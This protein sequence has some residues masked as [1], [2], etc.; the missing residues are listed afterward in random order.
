M[1]YDEFID[2]VAEHGDLSREE[3]EEVTHATL[4]TLAE[5]ITGGEADDVASQLPKR[6]QDPL[7]NTNE[8]AETFGLEEFKRR[9][10]ERGAEVDDTADAIRA[11]MTTLREALTG[12]EFDDLMDQL[13][14]EF[15]GIVEPAGTA[16]PSAR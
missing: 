10:S 1:T 11:V 7:R 4:Q 14:D 9:V 3:A 16:R 5:R 13:P 8:Q 15:W 2:A 6:L 12:G